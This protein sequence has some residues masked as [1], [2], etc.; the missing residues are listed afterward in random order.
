[1]C[2][3]AQELL[4]LVVKESQKMPEMSHL[5]ARPLVLHDDNGDGI[6]G[7]TLLLHAER[8]PKGY[9]QQAGPTLHHT[10]THVHMQMSACSNMF[11]R[12]EGKGWMNQ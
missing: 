9:K 12:V 3:L 8:A 11:T 7:T 4:A 6:I 5:Q 10:Q 2:R 1:M